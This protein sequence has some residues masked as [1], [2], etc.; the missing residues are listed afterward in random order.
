MDETDNCA[1]GLRD[2]RRKATGRGYS[3][4]HVPREG[5]G[6]AHYLATLNIDTVLCVRFDQVGIL[7]NRVKSAYFADLFGITTLR[8]YLLFCFYFGSG[9]A[10]PPPPKKKNSLTFNC[11]FS[12]RGMPLKG[13]FGL[14]PLSFVIFS[15]IN[16]IKQWQMIPG[17]C[18]TSGW[19]AFRV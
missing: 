18:P 7:P 14:I 6:S 3:F 2:F 17:I 11:V 10:P 1:Y 12:F 15:I 16:K 8:L 5:N 9:L 4:G 19:F 13:G